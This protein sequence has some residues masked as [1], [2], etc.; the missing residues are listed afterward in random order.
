MTL[1]IGTFAILAYQ[2][3]HILPI[4]RGRN[5]NWSTPI[6]GGESNHKLIHFTLLLVTILHN[7]LV[8]LSRVLLLVELLFYLL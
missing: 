6:G 4:N 3:G 2:F 5:H 1:A 7:Y 8:P